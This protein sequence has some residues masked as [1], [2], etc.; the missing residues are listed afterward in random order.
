MRLALSLVLAAVF[1]LG[2]A[3]AAKD[4][5]LAT[6][7]DRLEIEAKQIDKVAVGYNQVSGHYLE[8]KLGKAATKAFAEFTQKHNSKTVSTLVGTLVVS[9]GVKIMEMITSGELVLSGISAIT[10]EKAFKA[11]RG[12]MPGGNRK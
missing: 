4:L 2:P 10:A 8:L 12:R 9:R 6:K 7:S 5:V 1:V 11:L 3:A